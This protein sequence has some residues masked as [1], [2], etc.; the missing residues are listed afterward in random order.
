MGNLHSVLLHSGDGTDYSHRTPNLI[1]C[2][3]LCFIGDNRIVDKNILD[4]KDICVD[5]TSYI[6]WKH[7]YDRAWRFPDEHLS[8]LNGLSIIISIVGVKT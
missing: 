2:G 4:V 1:R 7:L 8:S 3:L 6:F 5:I